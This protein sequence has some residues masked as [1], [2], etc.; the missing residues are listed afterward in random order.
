MESVP[1]PNIYSHTSSVVRIR[2]SLIAQPIISIFLSFRFVIYQ[3]DHDWF[4]LIFQHN[5]KVNTSS[6]IVF[7]LKLLS[8]EKASRCI[9]TV[10]VEVFHPKEKRKMQSHF[11]FVFFYQ[12]SQKSRNVN[13]TKTTCKMSDNLERLTQKNVTS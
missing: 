6:V 7:F 9:A 2:S 5:L 10:S 4:F 11:R 3:S 12:P 1:K 13:I 8:F